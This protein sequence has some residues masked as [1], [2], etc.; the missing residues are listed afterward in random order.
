MHEEARPCTQPGGRRG[1]RRIAA[2]LMTLFVLAMLALA[3]CDAPGGAPK[4]A[5]AEPDSHPDRVWVV[6]VDLSGSTLPVRAQYVALYKEVVN[7]ME[8]GDSLLVYDI[9]KNSVA[10]AKKL[11]DVE[12]PRPTPPAPESDDTSDTYEARLAEWNAAQPPLSAD[13][14]PAL[15][16]GVIGTMESSDS[17][18]SDILGAVKNAQRVFGADGREPRLVVIS[19]MLLKQGKVDLSTEKGAKKAA[20]W[21]QAHPEAL[22]DLKGAR[23]LV[24]GAG[25]E[26]MTPSHSDLVKSFWMQYFQSSNSQLQSEYYGR[27]LPSVVLNGF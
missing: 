6:L 14:A 7:K 26:G 16:A 12:A 2:A 15:D 19:D 8:R 10:Q 4:Q 1:A 9:S 5:A 24:A 17:G 23:V 11:V 3:G 20:G 27:D 13:L 22:A 21:L 25:K 18:G